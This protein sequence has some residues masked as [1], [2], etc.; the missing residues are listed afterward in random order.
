MKEKEP[1]VQISVQIDEKLFEKIKTMAK[2]MNVS[3]STL[4]RN[5]IASGYEDAAMIDKIGLLAA[6]QYGRN[7]TKAIRE[8]IAKG[9]IRFKN[10]ELK[11]DDE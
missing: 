9:T 7:L 3:R 2:K 4:V 8:G 11:M 6:F 10:G 5:L 1:Y